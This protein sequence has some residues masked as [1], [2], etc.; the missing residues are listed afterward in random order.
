M[1]GLDKLILEALDNQR[2]SSNNY[3]FIFDKLNNSDK[4][5]EFLN[6][7]NKNRGVLLSSS[8]IILR[9]KEIAN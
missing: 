7:L 5:I 4:K 1:S 3:S 9:L 2:I 6:Y 8:E